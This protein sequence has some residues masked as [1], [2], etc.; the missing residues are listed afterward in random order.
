G[1]ITFTPGDTRAVVTIDAVTESG[2][3]GQTFNGAYGT[4]TI[5]AGADLAAGTLNYSYTLTTS[6]SGDDTFDSFAVEVTD[7]NDDKA[8]GTLRI[9]IVDDVPHA[10][11]FDGTLVNEPVQ[12][13]S[14]LIDYGL[15][16]DGFGD[17]T[18]SF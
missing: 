7:A 6:T 4:L 1:A 3:A 8:S 17:V 13:L 10:V 15:G 11:D 5:A 18:L 2:T 9:A 12:V 16:A 14:G